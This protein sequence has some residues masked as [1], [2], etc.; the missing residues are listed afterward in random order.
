MMRTANYISIGLLFLLLLT[1]AILYLSKVELL[2]KPLDGYFEKKQEP[3]L[4]MDSWFSG[5][6]QEELN[7]YFEENLYGRD[8]LVR[9]YNQFRFWLFR[10][11]SANGTIIGKQNVLFQDFYINALLGRDAVKI[12]TALEDVRKFKV[13]QDSLRKHNIFLVLAI[14]PGKASFFPEYLP[15]SVDLK[16]GSTTNYDLYRHELLKSGCDFIDLKQFLLAYKSVSRHPLFPKNGTHWSGYAVTLVMDT[17]SKYI[18]SKSQFDLRD[19]KDAGG[20]VASNDL[21]FTDN[22]IGKALNLLIPARNWEMYYPNI[23]FS[24]PKGRKP[25]LLSIGDSFNQSFWGFYPFFDEMFGDTTNYWY[26]NR[27]VAWPDSIEK[28]QINV[29]TMDLYSEVMKRD[30]V[31]IVTTEQNLNSFTFDFVKEFYSYVEVDHQTFL[32]KR[33]DFIN[34][35]NGDSAWLASVKEKAIKNNL[36]LETMIRMDAEWMIANEK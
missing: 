24:K 29:K 1:P 36:P 28:L 23:V 32:A 33:Q 17:L 12:E 4:S 15:D 34:S 27:I 14:A 20:R 6:Y 18:E 35:I 5:S 16:T 2:T 30:I 21:K 10:Q 31:L 26:Y 22:D 7:K 11:T 25:N 9:F 19:F 8:F 13:I 3:T